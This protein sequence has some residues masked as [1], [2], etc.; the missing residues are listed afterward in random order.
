MKLKLIVTVDQNDADHNT[1]ISDITQEELT[2]LLPVFEA[3]KNFRPYKVPGKGTYVTEWGHYHN[4][5]CG[6]YSP[7]EDLGEKHPAEIYPHLTEEQ[8]ETF[9]DR[10]PFGEHGFHSVREIRLLEITDDRSLL[11]TDAVTIHNMKPVQG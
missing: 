4:W 11:E 10:C 1:K 9:N 6:E 8:I 5:P 3:I 2:E 7:R